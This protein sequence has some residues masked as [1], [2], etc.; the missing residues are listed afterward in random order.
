MTYELPPILLPS[1]ISPAS[2]TDATNSDT[3]DNLSQRSHCLR[4]L[5]MDAFGPKLECETDDRPQLLSAFVQ[6]V[7]IMS[8]NQTPPALKLN[9]TTFNHNVSAKGQNWQ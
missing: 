1:A 9:I 7:K 5:T 2:D 4:D 6:V 3:L 8:N